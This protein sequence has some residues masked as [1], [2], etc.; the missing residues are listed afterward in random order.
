MGNTETEVRQMI[1]TMGAELAQMY[2][3]PLDWP[4]RWWA[5]PPDERQAFHNAHGHALVEAAKMGRTEVAKRM[6]KEH[7][8]IDKALKADEYATSI[9][10]VAAKLRVHVAKLRVHEV[11]L[12][13]GYAPLAVEGVPDTATGPFE[14]IM[15]YSKGFNLV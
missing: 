6:V 15:E 13:M 3:V 4:G 5:I 14:S 1:Q 12:E 9:T 7:Y 11:A 10:D 2:G 8:F